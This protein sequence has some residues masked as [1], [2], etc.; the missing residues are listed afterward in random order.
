MVL[1]ATFSANLV[2]FLTISKTTIR[3]TNIDDLAAQTQY[4]IALRGN[5]AIEDLFKVSISLVRKSW[6]MKNAT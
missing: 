5:T 2:A 1:L 4:R 6:Y 3:F